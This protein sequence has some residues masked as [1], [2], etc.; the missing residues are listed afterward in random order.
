MPD[1]DNT[2][3]EVSRNKEE[4]SKNNETFNIVTKLESNSPQPKR[5]DVSRLFRGGS[6]AEEMSEDA[7]FFK[8]TWGE[9]EVGSD[10]WALL[11]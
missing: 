7:T 3:I 5:V 11:V 8:S 4:I 10:Y 9:M 1:K 2:S 6:V